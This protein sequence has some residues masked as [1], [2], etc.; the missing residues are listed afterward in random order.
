MNFKDHQMAARAISLCME[1]P[2]NKNPMNMIVCLMNQK[3]KVR[4]P[5]Q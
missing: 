2:K 1:D 4:N 3:K 5:K